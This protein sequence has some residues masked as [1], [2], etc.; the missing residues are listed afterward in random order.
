MINYYEKIDFS[1]IVY[2]LANDL[3]GIEE[4]DLE[5]LSREYADETTTPQGVAPRMYVEDNELRTWG[6]GGN[7]E[8]LV[9]QFE[10]SE[11]AEHALMLSYLYDLEHDVNAPTVFYS[12]ADAEVS[13]A[14]IL[15]DAE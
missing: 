5:S 4:H 1:R 6:C 14:E 11:Q 10:T 7:N 9:E 8:A 3:S 13:L 2:T 12:R 15:E